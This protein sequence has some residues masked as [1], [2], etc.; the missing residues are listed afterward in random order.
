MNGSCLRLSTTRWHL[1]YL[2]SGRKTCSKS[3]SLLGNHRLMPDISADRRC[4]SESEGLGPSPSPSP[5][6]IGGVPPGDGCE[7]STESLIRTNQRTGCPMTSVRVL[8]RQP[9]C[10]G[11]ARSS[12]VGPDA[13]DLASISKTPPLVTLEN[14]KVSLSGEYLSDASELA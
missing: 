14:E 2:S 6:R 3:I 11:E 4:P 8:S 5:R 13:C 1:K 9:A 12:T 7:E 10:R